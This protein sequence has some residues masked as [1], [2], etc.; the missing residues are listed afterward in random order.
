MN[1]TAPTPVTAKRHRRDFSAN[2]RGFSNETEDGLK[3]IE[4]N[5]DNAS[6]ETEKIKYSFVV[7]VKDEQAT[8]VELYER[9]KAEI[10]Q[11]GPFEMIFVDDGSSDNSWKSIE[12]LYE[13]DPAHIRGL[14]FRRNA[15]KAAAL[16][17][18]FR[19]A[20]GAIIFT[21]D[22]DLQDDPK[23]IR[24]FLAKLDEGYDMV[25]GWKQVRHDPWHKVFPSR[26]FNYMLSRVS[27]VHLHDHNCGFKC[28][29]AEVVK[30]ITL[31]GEL[32]RMVPALAAIDGFRATEI[33]VEHHPRKHGVS[34]YGFERYLRGFVD[35]LVVGFF[36][37]YRERPG[38]FMGG[39]SALCV[40]IAFG[41]FVTGMSLSFAGIKTPALAACLSGTMFLCTGILGGF[42]SLLSEM[43]LRGGLGS[44]WKLPIIEDTAMNRTSS[45]GQ[46]A[47]VPVTYHCRRASD[48]SVQPTSNS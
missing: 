19:A 8:I 6:R 42:I 4:R 22:A 26:I 3:S 10:G 32:H 29:R 46:Q 7:P 27:G 43:T 35:M 47:P 11:D 44:H 2:G 33:V 25:S 48:N 5:G 15:G 9:I 14:R 40:A 36:R 12:T 21:L 31:H 23:E 45:T 41:S 24:R 18:G 39:M 16:T 38:H 37:K 34:K 17:A 20:R 30:G 28:Y 13:S 1:I